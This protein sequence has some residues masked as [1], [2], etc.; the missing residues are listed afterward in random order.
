MLRKMLLI[1][2]AVAMPVGVVAATAGTASAGGVIDTNGAPATASCT[3]S[4]GSLSFKTPIGIVTT[5][6]YQAPVKNKGN[7]IT[8]AGVT[9]TC[10]SSA[11]SQGSFTGTLSGK[12]K[13]T[14]RADTPAQ[15]YSC[16]ALT[17]VSPAPGGTLSGVLKIA[18][19]AP[20]GVKLSA[21]K[22]AIVVTSIL[23]GVNGSS[24]GTFTIPGHPGTGSVSGG[25]PGSDGGA[26]STSTDAT[27]ATETTL[28]GDCTST[29]GLSTIALG[30][31]TAS[32]K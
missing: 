8:V 6:G 11:V 4:G 5:N 16:T 22:S 13:T 17:G 31:G 14:N 29:G 27:A 28:A 20:A 7:Q 1:A 24:Q 19:H 23:G 30:S 15:E 10:T 12:I 32:L 3:T 18:W 2:A 21:K 25:F 9:L 26:T